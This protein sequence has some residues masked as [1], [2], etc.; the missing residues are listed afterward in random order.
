M[1]KILSLS[2]LFLFSSLAHANRW[3]LGV[4]YL[5]NQMVYK[6]A[7]LMNEKGHLNGIGADFLFN[8]NPIFQLNLQGKWLNGNLEYSG[9]TFSGT[10]LS[11]TTKDV[12]TEYRGL[13]AMKLGRLHFYSGYGQR[14]WFDDLVISYRREETYHYIPIGTR[15]ILRP[16][17]LSY[18]F[19]HFLD[20]LNSSHMGD[21][22][23]G[24]HDVT[25]KQ[26]S[27][28]GYSLELGHLTQLGRFDVKIAVSYEYW[29]IENSVT[30]NDGV[31]TLVEPHN[32]TNTY[33]ASIGL[34][35]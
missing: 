11:Q 8:F 33:G 32:S 3:G 12:V 18:E 7:A 24:R 29:N 13:L 5:Y 9:A 17:Y 19:R 30:S 25:M 28:K 20:G 16:F 34:F 35:Y 10:P 26:K 15:L 31:N 27:G 22:G 6:E 14:Y 1:N 4:S 2:F 23:G 21:I